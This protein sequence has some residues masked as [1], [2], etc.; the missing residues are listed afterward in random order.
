MYYQPLIAGEIPYR[1]FLGR[2]GTGGWHWHSE[3][4]LIVCLQGKMR[5]QLEDQEFY[6][7]AGD[8]L[9]LPGCCAHSSIC[10]S[11]DQWRLAIV[12]GYGLLRKQFAAIRDVCLFLPSGSLAPIEDLK[13]IFRAG[14]VTADNEWRVRGSL[15]HL[16]QALRDVPGS[17]DFSADRRSRSQRLEN[18]YTVLEYVRKHYDQKITVE[19]M[20]EKAGY[21]KTYF[22]RQFKS[23]TGSSFYRYLTCYRISVACMLMEDNR[24]SMAAIAKSTGFSSLPLFSRAFKEVT[25]MTPSQF[26]TLPAEEKNVTWIN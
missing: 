11:E 17:T 8:S 15:F 4:E 5:L 13:K 9:V 21:A 12:F 19:Q 1:V 2:D 10:E 16:C 20:A 25:G 7:N 26:Q 14:G 23:I 3:M 6:L 22:C 18:I 24:N